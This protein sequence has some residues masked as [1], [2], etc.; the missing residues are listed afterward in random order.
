MKELRV[1]KWNRDILRERQTFMS[2]A[3]ANAKNEIS[4]SE[5]RNKKVI[6]NLSSTINK[7]PIHFCSYLG[8]KFDF[9]KEDM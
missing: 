8:R 7:V 5:K 4:M 9:G 3:W 6:I 2:K 1:L